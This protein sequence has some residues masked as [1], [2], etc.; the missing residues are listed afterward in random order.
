MEGIVRKVILHMLCI[1]NSI[2]GSFPAT[3]V[4][5]PGV[6]L[7]EGDRYDCKVTVKDAAD[8]VDVPFSPLA[9]P[10]PAWSKR[11]ASVKVH[12]LSADEVQVRFAGD[13]ISF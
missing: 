9:I 7:F 11:H 5:G 10:G 1:E 8:R 3:I 13:T 4:K 6:T 2:G 12:V